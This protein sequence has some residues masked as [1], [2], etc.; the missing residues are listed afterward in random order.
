MVDFKKPPAGAPAAPPKQ[1]HFE[2]DP[3]AAPP[4]DDPG[5]TARIP[6]P[7]PIPPADPGAT[8]RMPAPRPAAPPDDGATQQIRSLAPPPVP[9][10][11][12]SGAPPRPAQPPPVP[13]AARPA[14]GPPPVPV[15]AKSA[16]GPPPAPAAALAIAA[17]IPFPEEQCHNHPGMA[18]RY[19]CSNERCGFVGCSACVKLF[20][21]KVGGV[22]LPLCWKCG[23]RALEVKSRETIRAE[24]GPPFYTQLGKVFAYP[25]HPEGIYFFIGLLIARGI[26]AIFG[27]IGLLVSVVVMLYGLTVIRATARGS[28][29]PPEYDDILDGTLFDRLWRVAVLFVLYHLPLIAVLFF[30]DNLVIVAALLLA[31]LIA[32]LLFPMAWAVL[33]DWG[34]WQAAASPIFVATQIAKV[35]KEYAI[36]L[37]L[38]VP[39]QIG[40]AVAEQLIDRFGDAAANSGAGSA[41][42]LFAMGLKFFSGLIDTYIMIVMSHMMGR[43]LRERKDVLDWAG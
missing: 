18:S 41:G 26:G 21:A 38:T 33:A 2:P 32:W 12:T 24:A 20:S 23:E 10:R 30:L 1:W 15:S 3:K 40:G 22:T 19:H 27:I 34:T 4:A 35:P 8:A 36:L 28:D 37:A 7:P 31:Q 9:A 42:L 11:A 13:A 5:A 43:L 39:I 6:V 16:S 14:G 25:L 17:G 29:V